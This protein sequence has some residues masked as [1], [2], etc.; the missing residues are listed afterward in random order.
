MKRRVLIAATFAVALSAAPARSTSLPIRT[1]AVSAGVNN[2][3]ATGASTRPS[4]SASGTKVAFDSVATNLA[5]DPNGDVRDVFVRDV[6]ADTTRLVS[7]GPTAEPANGPSSHAAIGGSV[8]AFQSEASNLV[9]GDGNGL[10]DIFARGESGPV[11]RVSVSAD[12]GDPNGLSSDADISSDGRYVAFVSA[13]SN[14]VPG[15][16]NGVADVF[17]RDLKNGST[18]RVSERGG[19]DGDGASTAPAISPDG[20]FVSFASAAKNLVN[21]DGNGVQDVFLADLGRARIERMSVSS[22]EREQNRAVIEPFPQISD[23][24]RDGRFVAFDSDATNLVKGDRNRDTDVFVRDRRAGTTGRVSIDKFGFEADNDSFNPSISPTGRF[25]VFQSFASRLAPGDGPKEDVFLYDRERF[26]PTVLSVGSH[27]QKREKEIARQL[28]Q[29][30]R[31]NENGL[32]AA[33]TSTAP[34]LVAD[35]DNKAEDV[36]LRVTAAPKARIVRGASGT[37]RGPRPKVVL[38]ADDRR[39]TDFLCNLDGVRIACGRRTTLPRI[40]PGQHVLRV[41]AGG[42]GMLFQTAPLLRVFRVSG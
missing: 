19:A 24:S 34:N 36:F 10:R 17:V 3:S 21:D 37:V 29:R 13:A 16:D 15:D 2:G 6:P 38:S 27:G 42:P 12:G 20:G 9:A 35:D 25:V 4:L 32:L 31:I 33:F 18:V 39:V 26:A 41:R 30:P 28:L 8:V 23:V 7:Q 1:Y 40:G 11:V 14:L 22:A 5:L